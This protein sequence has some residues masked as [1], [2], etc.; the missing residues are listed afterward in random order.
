MNT[1]TSSDRT[2]SGLT[3]LPCLVLALFNAAAYTSTSALACSSSDCAHT[4]VP[5]D[6]GR[7][8]SP[9]PCFSLLLPWPLF[10]VWC[11]FEALDCTGAGVLALAPAGTANVPFPS[12]PNFPCFTS[13][14]DSRS[15]C[16]SDDSSADADS[17]CGATSTA[18]FS[19]SGERQTFHLASF[20]PAGGMQTKNFSRTFTPRSSTFLATPKSRNITR[21]SASVNNT[22]SPLRVETT[23]PGIAYFSATSTGTLGTNLDRKSV[24]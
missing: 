18:A 13:S 19:V 4:G 14:I 16:S 1:V 12:S 5:D 8:G 9:L 24:V 2:S 3:W 7:L 10:E 17:G 6:S 22:R 23:L 21:S 20:F 15:F 11:P